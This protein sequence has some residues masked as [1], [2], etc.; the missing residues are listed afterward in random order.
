M[1]DLSY[2]KH[3][4]I[5]AI[6]DSIHALRMEVLRMKPEIDRYIITVQEKACAE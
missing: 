3:A 5:Q 6:L 1:I 2:S 4:D